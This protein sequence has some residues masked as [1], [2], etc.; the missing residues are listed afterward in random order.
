[1]KRKVAV[2]VRERANDDEACVFLEGVVADY[3]CR[4]S[5]FSF[6]G[7]LGSKRRV[8]KLLHLQATK[9]WKNFCPVGAT[10]EPV[11]QST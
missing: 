3:E 8:M 2:G 4:E 6:V 7:G 1:M 9:Q 5:A 11:G 10:A